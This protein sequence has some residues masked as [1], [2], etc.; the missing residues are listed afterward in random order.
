MSNLEEQNEEIVLLVLKLLTYVFKVEK[1]R[2]FAT[3]IPT[4]KVIKRHISFTEE[5]K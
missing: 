5:I 2:K 1:F 4:T 3:E